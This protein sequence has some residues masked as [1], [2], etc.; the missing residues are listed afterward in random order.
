MF[1]IDINNKLNNMEKNTKNILIEANRKGYY[2]DKLGNI[3]STKQKIALRKTKQNYYVF[4]IRFFGERVVIPVHRYVAYLKFN[5]RLFNDGIVVRHLDG[6]S[7]NNVWEN[8]EIGTQTDNAMDVP[9][10][11]R[12]ERAINA[13]KKLRKFTDDEV[14]EIKKDRNLGFTYKQLCKKYKT[15]KSTL[16]YMF[17]NAT[18]CS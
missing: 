12:I 1:R 9:K 2:T 10:E 7:L 5:E 3:F 17:N 18:Y 15:S 11:K 6:N 14:I 16:S 13:S 4:T 8:I